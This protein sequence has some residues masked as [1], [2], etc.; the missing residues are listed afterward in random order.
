MRKV[1]VP[2][3]KFNEENN[4]LVDRYIC[5]RCFGLVKEERRV[6]RVKRKA[7]TKSFIYYIVCPKCISLRS[8]E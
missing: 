8:K 1:I 2:A 4:T 5:P 3:Y 7:K 6:V